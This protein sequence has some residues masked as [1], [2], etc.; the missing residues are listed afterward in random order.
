MPA[1]AATLT[2]RPRI[3]PEDQ[4][5]ADCYAL[6]AAL[7]GRA[8]DAGLLKSLG[9]APRLPEADGQPF[10]RAYNRLLDASAA[11]DAD[12]ARQEYDDLFV[13]VGKSEIDPHA[14]GWRDEPGSQRSLAALRADLARLGLGRKPESSL[15]EDHI[16]AL[17]ETMRMLICGREGI[18]PAALA[19][20]KTF[21]ERYLEPWFG[22]FCTATTLC[23]L[24]NYY[25][26]VAEFG[27]CFLA[28]ERDS[29]AME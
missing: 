6:L 12:A 3:E 29:L 5:R 2:Y 28:I 8:P 11:M 14:A 13:G 23:P 4:A 15:Y 16:A 21:F 22:R 18:A 26:R 1:P 20:Q 27:N 19:E 25:Q 9:D 24:A 10:A 7:Y 17:C